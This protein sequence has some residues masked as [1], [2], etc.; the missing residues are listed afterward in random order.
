[1]EDARC[2]RGGVVSKSWVLYSFTSSSS[3]DSSNK[4]MPRTFNKT[5]ML[6]P[7][8]TIVNSGWK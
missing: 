2:R 3:T 4:T 1:M 6:S 5:R 8:H 7:A